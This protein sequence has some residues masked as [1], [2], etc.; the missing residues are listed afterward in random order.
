MNPCGVLSWRRMR[1]RPNGRQI[2]TSAQAQTEADKKIIAAEGDFATTRE[3]YRH[4][5]Q[6]NLDAPNKRL[7]DLDVEAR[8]AGAAIKPDLAATVPALRAQRDAFVA[9][10]QSLSNASA[11]TWDAT[12]NRLDK[13]WAA[14]KSAVDKV[15]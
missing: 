12:K 8:T 1:R 11:P 14:L 2:G 4:T 7:A 9:D 10:F 6:S 15:D 3:D 5:V 13:E